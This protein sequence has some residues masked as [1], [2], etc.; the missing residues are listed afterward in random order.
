[1]EPEWYDDAG[2]LAEALH[3]AEQDSDV[4][5]AR[6]LREQVAAMVAAALP[7]GESNFAR[8]RD[9]AQG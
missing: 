7:Q 4:E 1:M 5:R 2:R 3:E 9:L 6:V 8:L